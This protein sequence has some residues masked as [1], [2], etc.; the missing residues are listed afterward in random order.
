MKLSSQVIGFIQEFITKNLSWKKIILFG[1]AVGVE[2]FFISEKLNKN[3]PKYDPTFE[4]HEATSFIFKNLDE[5]YGGVTLKTF[6]RMAKKAQWDK[7][8][9][10][11]ALDEINPILEQTMKVKIDIN[12]EVHPLFDDLYGIETKIPI[13]LKNNGFTQ[14]AS[15]YKKA[16]DGYLTNPRGSVGS[17]RS[18]MEGL[19]VAILTQKGLNPTQILKDNLTKL[20]NNSVI[21]E[22]DNTDC[23]RCHYKKRDSEF[24]TAYDTYSLLSHYGSHPGELTDEVSEYLFI[25]GS[26]FINF[27]IKRYEKSLI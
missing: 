12:G 11:E 19:V 13:K 3:G 26:A 16:Y 10:Q 8:Q 24:N 18:V 7:D 20:E 21:N 17:V 22:I 14:L 4:K 6:M 5:D 25:I 1:S 15:D 27:I 9:S 2:T 23:P